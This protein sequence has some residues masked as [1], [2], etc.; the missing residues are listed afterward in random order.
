MNLTPFFKEY[1]K[2]YEGLDDYLV[3]IDGQSMYEWNYEDGC[4][5][6]GASR[7]YKLTG[8][9]GFYRKDGESLY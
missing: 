1:M 3:E 9:S 4:L 2:N 7:L 6:V 8:V 5:F